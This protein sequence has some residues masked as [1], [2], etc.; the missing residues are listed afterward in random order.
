MGTEPPNEK[1]A[2]ERLFGI[3]NEKEFAEIALSTLR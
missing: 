3:S 2:A 1:N